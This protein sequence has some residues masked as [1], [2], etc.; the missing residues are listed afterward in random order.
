MDGPNR[1]FLLDE[2]EAGLHPE[3]S[4]RQVQWLH[5]RVAQGCQFM[6]A[7]HSMTLASLSWAQVIHFRADNPPKACCI[8]VWVGRL[9]C[10]SGPCWSCREGEVVHAG[11]GLDSVM[12]TVEASEA[13]LERM[14]QERDRLPQHITDLN[15]TRD[16]LDGLM[17]SA[18]AHRKRMLAE[19]AK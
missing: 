2:P 16:A 9:S 14:A 17:A 1:L 3:A 19:A 10:G 5:E 6:A 7:T 18:R 11:D 15:R 12:E 13:A 4:A 8:R